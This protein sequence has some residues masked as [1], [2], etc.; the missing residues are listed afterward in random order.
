MTTRYELNS[1]HSSLKG[2]FKVLEYIKGHRTK[3]G[4]KV[5]PRVVIR[6]IDTGTVLNIQTTNIAAGKFKDYR[7][8]T[9]CG[10]GY[11]GSDVKI[12]ARGTYVRRVYDLW[13][14]MIK[15]VT[16]EYEGVSID[17]RWLNFTNFLNTISEVEGYNLWE[18]GEDVHLDKDLAGMKTYSKTYCKFIPASENVRESACRRWHKE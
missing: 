11:I 3:D 14:T 6:L 4:R 18:S 8:P 16:F 1:I 10:I 13:A 2:D 5:H 7:L 15:R 17:K 12:T 9:V